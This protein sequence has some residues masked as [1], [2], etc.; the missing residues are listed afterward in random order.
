V[1]FQDLISPVA[2][3]QFF[4]EY[5]ERQH[6][7]VKRTTPDYYARLLTL[8]NLDEAFGTN[9]MHQ[10]DCR[11]AKQIAVT[12]VHEC[13]FSEP[14]TMRTRV[15]PAKIHA[16][17]TSGSTI[18]IE[19]L[20]RWHTPL[21]QL[22]HSIFQEINHHSQCNVYVTP[23][24]TYGFGPHFDTHD[25]LILQLHNRKRWK[26]YPFE[27]ELPLASQARPL[28][29]FPTSPSHEIVLEPGDVLYV[30]R[31]MVHDADT[32]DG[33]SVHITL[34][35]FFHTWHDFVTD[36]LAIA[37]ATN[38]SLR[39]SL[40]PGF[41]RHSLDSVSE[42][43]DEIMSAIKTAV[44]TELRTHTGASAF[45]KR[46]VP[47]HTIGL[48]ANAIRSESVTLD[49]V[50]AH[51]TSHQYDAQIINGNAILSAGDTQLSFPVDAY[52]VIEFVVKSPT[53]GVRDLPLLDAG[54]Q[55]TVAKRLMKEGFVRLI[56]SENGI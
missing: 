7:Y 23:P 19:G 51:S 38:L 41:L 47:C 17:L 11:I 40:P 10:G 8:D 39:R 26:L 30:P 45:R 46:A 34:G 56:N 25:V 14:P 37:S 21:N 54:S 28:E 31:G 13:L 42:S 5:W 16:L 53:F 6:L 20:H 1:N 36:A 9:S 24:E 49:S 55:L 12:A 48:F 22:C 15:D 4:S 27:I 43:V 52:E 50:L 44:V 3:G 18:I 29:N 2:Q 33:T 32:L 35:I